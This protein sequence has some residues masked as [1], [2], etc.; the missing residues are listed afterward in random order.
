MNITGNIESIKYQLLLA[1]EKLNEYDISELEEALNKNSVFM[2][3][4]DKNNKIAVSWW[5]SAKRTR[6]YP[7]ERVY[8]TLNF[9]G[10]RITIIPIYKDEGAGGN[11]DF[12]Q[13]DTISLMSLLGVYVIIAYYQTADRNNK[14]KNK[15]K[16]KMTNQHFNVDYI[17]KQL[18]NL[19][20]YHSS[21]L[22]WNTEQGEK[23][24][25]LIE[26][27]LKSYKSISEKLGIKLHSEKEALNRINLFKTDKAAFMN[28]SR[29]LAEEAQTRESK[30]LQPKERITPNDKSII[31]IKDHLGGCYYFTTDE[32]RIKGESLFL[33]ECKH[34]TKGKLPSL[35]DI[36]DGLLKIILYYNLNRA[37]V[38]NKKY[39]PVP[40]LKMTSDKKG[41]LSV[42]NKAMLE[43]LYKEAKINKFRIEFNQGD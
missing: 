23:A 8:N 1:P 35:S 34:S 18:C 29:K 13:W 33:I 26:T 15:G 39:N 17:E 22:H 21:A 10:K 32:A 28:F 3:N 27:A 36:K 4:L 12:L 24:G 30:T 42:K 40:V 43:L 41:E 20:S 2:L 9:L 25:E 16:D 14:T 5:V 31:T 6:S 7:Y 38:S 19:K 37:T 11:R